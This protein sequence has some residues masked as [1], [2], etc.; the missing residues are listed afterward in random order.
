M[1][2]TIVTDSTT[3]EPQPEAETSVAPAVDAETSGMPADILTNTDT[4]EVVTE[5]T[6]PHDD[7]VDHLLGKVKDFLKIAGHDVEEVFEEVVSLAKKT[8]KK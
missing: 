1:T 4:P 2:D 3:P 5:V 8:V 6:P 7:S